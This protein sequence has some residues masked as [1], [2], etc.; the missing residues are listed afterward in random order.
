MIIQ[1]LI[2]RYGI[3]DQSFTLSCFCNVHFNTHFLCLGLPEGLGRSS[4]PRRS[5]LSPTHQTVT[6]VACRFWPST[7]VTCLFAQPVES[8]IQVALLESLPLLCKEPLTATFCRCLHSECLAWRCLPVRA[9]S[10]TS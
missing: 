6:S 4:V 3:E 2:Q 9:A 5:T 1:S 8:L 10:F 7:A